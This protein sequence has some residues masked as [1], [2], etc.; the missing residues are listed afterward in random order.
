M[1]LK[2]RHAL[3][4]S[5]LGALTANLLAATTA[6][7]QAPA[8]TVPA[9]ATPT[10]LDA[11]SD[12]G[13]GLMRID[14]AIL[15]YQ[16]A[17]GRVKAVEPTTSVTLDAADGEVLSFRYTA[18]TLTGATPN[19][20]TPWSAAQTFTTPARAPSTTTTVTGASGNA[21]LVTIP[22]GV[23]VRQY[24]TPANQLPLD[25]GFKDQRTAFDFNYSTPL[26]TRSRA[27]VGASYSTER[28][29]TSYSF[30]G[31][32][33]QDFNQHNTRL[34]AALNFEFDQSRPFFGTPTPFT[35]MSGTQKDSA[36]SKT[37][38][39]LVVGVTQAMTRNWLLQVNYSYGSSSG[40]Q[41]DP[42]RIISLVDSSTGAPLQY[43]YESRPNQRTRQSLY[44]G[45]KIAVGGTFADISAR[46]YH[47]NWG[48]SSYTVE[49]SDRIPLGSSFYVEPGVRYY[50][51]TKADFFHDYLANGSAMPRYASSD[52]RLGEFSADTVSLQLGLQFFESSEIYLRAEGYEQ[53]GQSHPAGAIGGLANQNLFTGVRAN[54]VM[55]GLSL[56]IY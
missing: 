28:D 26:G 55:L 49:A 46:L 25:P 52:S 30:N 41:N 22:G 34:S 6:H 39:N 32:F 18:D 11:G 2:P 51:Q 45:N 9:D 36:R 37:V 3:I 29:Y 12:I 47:D 10:T 15:F 53:H 56:S 24:T 8:S 54:S 50:N 19:G 20:A 27:S 40:Y 42:Y 38:E 4:G 14:S 17:G 5:A 13:S 16:E 31:G 1:Q 44:V 48:I 33:S 35:V 21:Q 23:I 7:A 43:L